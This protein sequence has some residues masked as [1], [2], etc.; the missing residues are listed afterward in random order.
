MLDH[1]VED[2]R[3]AF[4]VIERTGEQAL[5]EMRRLLGLL[6]QDDDQLALSPQPAL[7]QLG[8]LAEQVTASGL[9][10]DVRIEGPQVELP[11]GVDLS[12]YRIVQEA[13]TNAL[14]HAGPARALVRV[15]YEE[16]AVLLEVTDDGHG[17][18]NGGG[19]GHG[20]VGI[21]ERVALVGGELQAGPLDRG[22]FAVRARLPLERARCS[23]SSWRTTRRWCAPGSG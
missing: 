20:L 12:A 11:P 4:D 21:R 19:T 13:L 2:S 23:A 14:K 18:G 8:A 16:D 9:P 3:E 10:V 5:G 22:G 17:N 1:D 15:A 6:R 7:S